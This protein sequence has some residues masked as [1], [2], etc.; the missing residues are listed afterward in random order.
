MKTANHCTEGYISIL[1]F[2]NNNN[3]QVSKEC[4]KSLDMLSLSSKS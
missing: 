3:V 1:D 4:L 2:R